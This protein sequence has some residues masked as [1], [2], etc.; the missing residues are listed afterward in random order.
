M[1][2]YIDRHATLNN[3]FSLGK[4][5][6][7]SDKY[8]EIDFFDFT[9]K[10][11]VEKENQ[12]LQSTDISIAEN[13][14]FKYPIF[15]PKGRKKSDK[16]I[17]LLHGLNERSWNKY[18]TW[19]EYMCEN[20]GHPVILFPIAY[21][22]N[23]GPTEWSNPRMLSNSLNNRKEK[24][25]GDRSISFANVALSDRLS[26][27]PSRFYLSGRQTLFDVVQLIEEI[28]EGNHSTFKEGTDINIFAYSIGAFLSQ[29]ALMSNH[30]NLF[31][32]SRLFMFC[33]GSVFSS[34]F[35]VSRSILD[36]ASFMKLRQYYI[37]IFGNE[38][39]PIWKRDNIFSAF[40]KMITPDKYQKERVDI[41]SNLYDRIKGV[42]LSKDVVIP[43][44]GV[45]EAMGREYT[46]ASVSLMDFPFQYSHENPFPHNEKDTNSLNS[47]F[48][49][50]FSAATSFLI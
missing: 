24:Y 29:V 16:A 30:K 11:I 19:A 43:F 38:A 37:H 36:K 32:S 46:E 8:I 21:H 45:Q 20:T 10:S 22:I 15:T 40:R 49:N 48:N 50:V 33:G 42:A 4:N 47:A 35:G 41:F 17:L 25:V 39:L 27:H 23:R 28:K 13:Y 26:E 9:S 31:S 12:L 18:L 2:N 34:M 7:I 14:S 44:T 6:N 5:C 1:T 3:C